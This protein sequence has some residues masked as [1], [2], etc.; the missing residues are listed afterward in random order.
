MGR[1]HV[2]DATTLSRV[3][4][5]SAWLLGGAVLLAT[6]ALLVRLFTPHDGTIPPSLDS[7]LSALPSVVLV[8]AAAC[9]VLSALLF[10][11][12]GGLRLLRA[13]A[14]SLIR[15]MLG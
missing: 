6:N 10:T 5:T 3:L 11:L 7:F 15:R 9:A 14:G 12:A 13:G 2:L 1:T 4:H 8:L